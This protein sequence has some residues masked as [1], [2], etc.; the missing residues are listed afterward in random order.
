VSLVCAAILWVLLCVFWVQGLSPKVPADRLSTPELIQRLPGTSFEWEGAE[1]VSDKATMTVPVVLDGQEYWFQLD[2][3]SDVTM[4]Y[5]TREAERRG[6]QESKQWFVGV[7][8]V[9]VGGA[10]FDSVDVFIGEEIAGGGKTSGTLGLDLLQGKVVVLD[11]PQRRFCVVRHTAIP[12][13]VLK[14]TA[15]VPAEVRDNKLF[16]VI[17]AGDEELDGIFF[18]TGSSSFPLVVDLDLW[19]RL[20]GRKGQDDATSILDVSSWGET[21]PMVGAEMQGA[22][23]IGTARMDRAMVYYW[24]D[25]P[26]FFEEWPFPAAGLLGNA[27]FFDEV[28]VIDL[29]Q[30]TRL[31]VLR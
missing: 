1:G 8:E 16:V 13:E 12:S 17:R 29:G 30:P 15:F 24:G 21:V 26:R 28:V 9:R 27:L 2:T 5:G 14:R 20:T 4:L 11:F 25:Q 18:D 6:W 10:Y 7:P 23:E 22:L 3:G 19:Q 31:G